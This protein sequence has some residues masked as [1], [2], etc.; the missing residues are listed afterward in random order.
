MWRHGALFTCTPLREG[1]VLGFVFE[2]RGLTIPRAS[3]A[4]RRGQEG[5]G[6]GRK[7]ATLAYRGRD[8]NGYQM[9][10]RCPTRGSSLVFDSHLMCH[11]KWWSSLSSRRLQCLLYVCIQ[12]Y[13]DRGPT[14][15]S[16]KKKMMMEF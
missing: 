5:G 4:P 14:C 16:K 9:I 13:Y 11:V 15:P 7:L 2:G 1:G 8:R 3:H 10:R 12:L 6:G